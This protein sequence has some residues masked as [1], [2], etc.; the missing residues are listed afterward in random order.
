MI[1]VIDIGRFVNLS[2]NNDFIVFPVEI[3]C[4]FQT[5]VKLIEGK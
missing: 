4:L 3:D 2:K 1:F 5:I